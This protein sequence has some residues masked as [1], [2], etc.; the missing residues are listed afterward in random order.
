MGTGMGTG[1]PT[2]MT[3][4]TATT[5]PHGPVQAIGDA[6]TGRNTAGG[7]PGGLAGGLGGDR[8]TAGYGG[9]N[10]APTQAQ[11]GYGAG[12]AGMGTGRKPNAVKR[13]IGMAKIVKGNSEV[14]TL[15]SDAGEA[16]VIAGELTGNSAL[17]A[18]GEQKKACVLLKCSGIIC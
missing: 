16:E 1:G 10:M 18:K 13:V 3:G 6:L 14:L 7:G 9:G 2:G 4:G 11:A 17:A 12:G 8:Q 15:A 5:A